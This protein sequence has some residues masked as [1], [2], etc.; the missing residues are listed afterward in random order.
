[1]V[2]KVSLPNAAIVLLEDL[3]KIEPNSKSAVIFT[4]VNYEQKWLGDA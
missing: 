2:V 1:M 3:E 4:D